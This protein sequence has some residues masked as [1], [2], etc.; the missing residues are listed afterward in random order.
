MKNFT[1]ST[2][3]IP[4]GMSEQQAIRLLKQGDIQGLATLVQNNQV[5][6]VQ[7]AFLITHDRDLA[8]DIVQDA[9]LQTYRK[10]AQFDENRPFGPWFLRIVV[11]AAIKAAQRQ[12]KFMPYEE[13]E[14][15]NP[16]KE[17]LIDPSRSPEKITESIETSELV[18]QALK[19]L[20]PNQRAVVVLRYFLEKSEREMIQ[21]LGQPSTSI[22]WWLHIARKRLQQFLQPHVPGEPV[23]KEIEND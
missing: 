14:S 13:P 20:T 19:Q 16:I 21:K 7:A 15:G 9:F 4:N 1:D 8:E 22:K 23:K 6:S 10:I 5:K 2:L 17:W 12:R 18:W 11:N 3:D